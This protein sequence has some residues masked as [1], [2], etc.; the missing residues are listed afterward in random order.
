MPLFTFY[1]CRADGASPGFE[2]IECVD[3]AAALARARRVLEDHLSAAEVVVWR[4]ERRI[5]AVVR[6]TGEA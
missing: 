1:P 3:D 2:T 4:G 5:G 6:V